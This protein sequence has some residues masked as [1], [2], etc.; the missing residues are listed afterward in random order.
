[1]DTTT[2]TKT[3]VVNPAFLQEIK[4]SNPDLWY[5]VHRLRQL[6]DSQEEP[7]CLA[8]Q[9]VRQLDEL[10]DL[11]ALQFALEESYG[12]IEV[13]ASSVSAGGAE[14]PGHRTESSS[15]AGAPSA[16]G[17]S[18]VHSQ[19]CS[20]YLQLTDLAER[21]EELQYRGVAVAQL[22]QLIEQT[23]KFDAQLREHENFETGLIE[24]AFELPPRR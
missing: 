23:Q 3:L 18:R 11:L 9:L 10:R 24:R 5:A 21:A 17:S 14:G 16:D 8:R 4:D 13:A 1:M 7:A 6:C 2:S 19:H 20:L 15:S 12:F 22:R